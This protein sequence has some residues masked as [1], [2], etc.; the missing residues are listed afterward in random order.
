MN[1]W[2]LP[3]SIIDYYEPYRKNTLKTRV[4]TILNTKFEIDEKYEIIDA[5]I[6][7]YCIYIIV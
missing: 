5:S 1:R 4:T 7:I 6:Q 3:Q 2:K